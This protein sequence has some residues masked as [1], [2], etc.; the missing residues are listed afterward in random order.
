MHA[1][2]AAGH[3]VVEHRHAAEQRDVLEGARDADLRAACVGVMPSSRSPRKVMLPSCGVV[4]AVDDVEHRALAGAVGADDGA[5]L[6]LQHVEAD[7]GQRLHAAE[8]QRDRV[9]LEDRPADRRRRARRRRLAGHV[10]FMRPSGPARANTFTS[11]ILQ[12]GAPSPL[13]IAAIALRYVAPRTSPSTSGGIA[14]RSTSRRSL[15]VRVSMPS[16][17]SSSL[18]R[19]SEAVDLRSSR[20]PDPAQLRVHLGDARRPPARRPPARDAR[21]A[22][23]V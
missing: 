1:Q 15:P 4:D 19:I 20:A 7:V 6:V 10:M 18:C 13:S 3:D 21:S 8:A 5:D 2:R 11:R 22:W 17:A 23:P 9:E 16:S 12:A 14:R